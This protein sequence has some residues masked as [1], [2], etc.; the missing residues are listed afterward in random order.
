M[1]SKALQIASSVVN[2]IALALPV[3]SFDKLVMV[4]P[5][6]SDNSLSEIFLRAIITSKLT[7]II[8]HPLYC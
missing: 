8:I 5:T 2:R 1:Q 7:T 4:I 6:R 3:L